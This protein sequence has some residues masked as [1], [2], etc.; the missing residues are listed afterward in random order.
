MAVLQQ[1][2]RERISECECDRRRRRGREV[3]RAGLFADGAVEH[4]RGRPGETRIG[5][6]GERDD[7]D[8]EPGEVL[9]Q[10]AQFVAFTTLRY[11]QRAVVSRDNAEITVQA[12]DGVQKDR[13]GAG[14]R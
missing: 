12:F 13:W 14:R 11:Q 10:A 4:N 2:N 5:S 8:A 6:T 1:G 7:L 3:V 9:D